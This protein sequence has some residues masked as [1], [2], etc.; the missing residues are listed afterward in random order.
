MPQLG[1]G[2]FL[3][4]SGSECSE[5]VAAALQAGY[6]LID[7]AAAYGNEKDVAAGIQKSGVARENVFVSTKLQ[8]KEHGSADQVRAAFAASLSRLGMDYVDLFLIH[9]P[10]GGNI[11]EVWQVLLEIR[12]KGLA[13]AVGVSNFG[14]EHLRGLKEAGLEAPE[15]NQIELHCWLQQQNVTE[16][17]RQESIATMAYSPLARGQRF[18]EEGE[19]PLGQIAKELG[20]TEAS[21]A[22]RWSLQCGHIVIPKT[23]SADRIKQNAAE[24]FDISE[25][26]MRK[27]QHLDFG[28]N[29]I[30][31][32]AAMDLPWMNVASTIPEKDDKRKGKRGKAS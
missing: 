32:S 8:A 29:C 5:A 3:T 31:S 20:Q 7:T 16:Y 17:H 22:I 19:T 14:V 11:L 23:K 10:K 4:K 25:V 15:V 21:I 27:L 18:S 24:G 12:D 26:Q 30:C 1:L 13:R 6:R 9:S 2:T 28:F